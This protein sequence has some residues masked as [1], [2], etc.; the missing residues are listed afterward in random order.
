MAGLAKNR[1]AQSLSPA[2]SLVTTIPVLDLN[3]QI[4]SCRLLATG[5]AQCLFTESFRNSIYRLI[6]LLSF[7]AVCPREYG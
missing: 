7:F 3:R 6:Q 5:A 2:Q 1:A 4:G